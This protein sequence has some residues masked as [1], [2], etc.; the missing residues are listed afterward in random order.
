V[1]ILITVVI[2]VSEHVAAK[3]FQKP[4]RR[5]RATRREADGPSVLDYIRRIVP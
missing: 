5:W 3:E 4:E 1:K 2:K